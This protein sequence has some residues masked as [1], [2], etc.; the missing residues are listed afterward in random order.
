[1]ENGETMNKVDELKKELWLGCKILYGAGLV[2]ETGHLSVRLSNNTF[3][4]S[5][6]KSPGLVKLKEI[7]TL[8]WAGK[9]IDGH[10][11]PNSE[12]VIHL[13]IYQ[14]RSDVVSIAHTHSEMCIVL[15]SIG[16]SL[17]PI[18]N[19]GGMLGSIVPV[20][21]EIGLI[22]DLDKAKRMADVLGRQSALLLRG[23]GS[24][25]ATE[26]I[27]KTVIGAIR[28]EYCARLQVLAMGIGKPYYFSPEECTQL[29]SKLN[30]KRSWDYWIQTLGLE[31]KESTK[32]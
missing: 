28:L 24:I 9:V 19:Y 29:R 17:K 3:L 2:K 7:Q 16:E 18:H 15:G 6:R 20:H 27:K 21:S 11:E 32:K 13:A 30:L 22:Q 10:E 23:H 12:T 1:M 8:D 5:P 31:E 14:N 26:S 4:M 25:V